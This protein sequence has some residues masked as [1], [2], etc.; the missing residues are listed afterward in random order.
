MDHQHQ[1]NTNATFKA[2]FNTRE[3]I[4]WGYWGGGGRQGND[5]RKINKT[6]SWERLQLILRA[7]RKTKQM[8]QNQLQA[9]HMEDGERTVQRQVY[10][11]HAINGLISPQGVNSTQIHFSLFISPA[12]KSKQLG[13]R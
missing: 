3:Y 12:I 5:K 6:V 7:T 11:K 13:R 8:M 4:C 9:A 2:L 1:R 10:F